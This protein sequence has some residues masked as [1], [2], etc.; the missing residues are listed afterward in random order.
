MSTKYLKK[1]IDELH[2]LLR[3][4]IP[5]FREEYPEYWKGSSLM[6]D[7]QDEKINGKTSKHPIGSIHRQDKLII[8]QKRGDQLSNHIPL[9]FDL[10]EEPLNPPV[11]RFHLGLARKSGR[12]FSKIDRFNFEQR[13]DQARK[14]FDPSE[15]PAKMKLENIGEY[16]SMIHRVI[17]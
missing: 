17:S 14:T 4:R 6:Y 13:D 15:I 12:E 5:F 1:L 16:G 9:N 11:M 2:T 8:R 7:R 3:I 10:F